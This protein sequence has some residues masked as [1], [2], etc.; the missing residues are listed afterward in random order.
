MSP[1]ENPPRR[2][3]KEIHPERQ[4][5]NRPF[6]L[7]KKAFGTDLLSCAFRL[8]SRISSL[9]GETA[10]RVSGMRKR[11]FVFA[12]EEIPSTWVLLHG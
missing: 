10:G 7:E 2:R 8:A 3:Q 5:G 12:R 11:L 9:A 1:R 4:D 6:R